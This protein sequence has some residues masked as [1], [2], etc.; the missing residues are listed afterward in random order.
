MA[1]ILA[2]LHTPRSTPELHYGYNTHT[3]NPLFFTTLWLFFRCIPSDL[4]T[5]DGRGGLQQWQRGDHDLRWGNGPV[6]LLLRATDEEVC[7][8][9]T[10]RNVTG[11]PEGSSRGSRVQAGVSGLHTSHTVQAALTDSPSRKVALALAVQSRVAV[12]SGCGLS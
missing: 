9:P 12:K 11:A 5:R 6:K 4:A 3:Y 7:A 2:S 1:P 8:P 10:T